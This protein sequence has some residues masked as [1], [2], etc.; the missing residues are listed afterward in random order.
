MKKIP[1]TGLIAEADVVDVPIEKL[2]L[3]TENVRFKHLPKKL[4]PDEI[5]QRIRQ[6]D[7]T[8]DLCEQILAAGVVYEPL[9]INSDNIV[10]EGNRR[11]VCLR[12]LKEEISN[13]KLE[14]FPKDKFTTLK[15][16]ILPKGVDDKT[17]DL[18][19][20]T[21]HVKGKKPWK[22]FNRAKHIYRLNRFHGMSYDTLA[23]YLGMG[24][25]TIQRSIT[26]YHLILEY[27]RKFPDDKEWFHKFTYFE[28]LFKRKELKEYRDDKAFLIKFMKWIH[29]GKFHDHRDVRQLLKV[30]TDEDI[31]REFQKN[32][33]GAALNL[34]ESK[35]PS[36]SNQQ[37]KKIKDTID[38][39]KSMSRTEL[40]ELKGNAAKRKLIIALEAEVKSLLAELD[41]LNQRKRVMAT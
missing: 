38:V 23:D 27:S 15:C 39:L 17:V 33:F 7:D 8:N 41:A 4:S 21:I 37:F 11:L 13:G 40:E 24:K 25:V 22:L 36:L 5:E 35:D 2:R 6:E 30:I 18:Y 32:G 26:V 14:G 10:L 3:D 34:L 28:E 1:N 31:Y 16:R 20:A 29:D 9:V 19:L 12:M